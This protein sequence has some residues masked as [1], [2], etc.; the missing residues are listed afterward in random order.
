MTIYDAIIILPSQR[1]AIAKD[2]P[3]APAQGHSRSAYQGSH[4]QRV[5]L[6]YGCCPISMFLRISFYLV[7]S[8]PLIPRTRFRRL[9]PGC[10]VLCIFLACSRIFVGCCRFLG[11][12]CKGCSAFCRVLA[13]HCPLPPSR[14]ASQVV[15]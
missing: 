2:C 11:S 9:Y 8:R 7:S 4:R 10:L 3:A 12:L 14:L 5:K 15:P 13:S 6:F 1:L